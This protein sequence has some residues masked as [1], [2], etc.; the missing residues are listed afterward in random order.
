MAK[1]KR[2]LIDI[3]DEVVSSMTFPI[4]VETVVDNGDYTQTITTCDI[5]HA[6]EGFNVTINDLSYKIIAF[7]QEDE[8]LT[9][10]PN[11]EG[12]FAIAV[13]TIFYLYPLY[14]FHGNPVAT[15]TE[16]KNIK[17][18]DKTPMIWLWENF[19]EDVDEDEIVERYIP[20]ELYA[21]TQPTEVGLQKMTNDDIHDKCCKP[22]RRL[23]ENLQRKFVER[24]DIFSTDYMKYKTENFPKF[25]ITARS[26]GAEKAILMD[27]LSGVAMYTTLELWYQDKCECPEIVDNGQFNDSFNNS[28]A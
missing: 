19:T 17:A 10:Q 5:Y 8:S 22:M 3:L 21:L 16:L 18:N 15:Q 4:L 25:G 13:G 27:N 20:V 7:S 24:S 9:L 26:K 14:F 12:A 23:L 11:F 1:Y 28:F 6:Q 2:P